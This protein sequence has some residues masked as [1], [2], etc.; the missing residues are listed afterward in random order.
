MTLLQKVVPPNLP[1]AQD[2]Y[3][4]LEEEFFRNV[5]RLYF[6]QLSNLVN[7]LGGIDGGKYIQF[8]YGAFHQDG[9]TTL[10]TGITNVSTTPIVVGSTAGFPSSGWIL[11]GS[12]II[13]YTTKTATTLDGTITRGALGTSQAAHLAGAA[14]SEVQGTGSSTTIGTVLFNNTDYSNGV[15]AS[16]DY[17]KIYFDNAGIYNLQFSVQL[18]NYTSAEDNVT[19]WFRKN[20][21]D[22]SASASIAEVP[23]KHGTSPGATIMTVNLFYQMA[24]NDYV[25]LAWSS[26]TGNTVIATAPAGTSPVHPASPGLIFTAQFVSALTS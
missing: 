5:L 24:A 7:N 4:R 18:L 19:V 21:T 16:A 9:T 26:D 14:I 11:I 8:P 12:E 23:P 17:T 3:I 6:N 15:Y 10:T 22:I 2:G 20:G 13:Q 1:I 25:S